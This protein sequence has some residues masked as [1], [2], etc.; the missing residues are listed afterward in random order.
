M[1]RASGFAHFPTNHWSL[2]FLLISLR[3]KNE[4][5]ITFK[6]WCSFTQPVFDLP[7]VFPCGDQTRNVSKDPSA[8]LDDGE[9]VGL[10][11]VCQR[12]DQ[13]AQSSVHR[14]DGHLVVDAVSWQVPQSTQKTLQGRLLENQQNKKSVL[15]YRHRNT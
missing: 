11:S 10:T 15:F 6:V 7:I 9:W 2:T 8:A 14:A 5:V 1:D 13:E 3:Y 4:P 12:A